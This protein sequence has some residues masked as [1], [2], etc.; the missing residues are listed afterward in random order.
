MKCISLSPPYGSLV[1][2]GLKRIETRGWATS[3]RG[4][5]A[6]HQTAAPGPKGTTEAALWDRCLSEPFR[7]A[8][9][10]QGIGNPAR[11]PRG[12][13]VAVVELL[14]CVATWPSWASV[15]PWFTA[16]H[17]DACWQVPPPEP[18]RSFGDY[19]PGRY[20][21][22]LSDVRALPAPVPARGMPGLW[23]VDTATEAAIAQQIDRTR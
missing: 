15:E 9:A 14:D 19:R 6:I 5:L 21:W 4:P 20:A 17:G 1:A 8:L 16:T 18:E 2:F 12:K 3:Y 7:S 10:A 11:L 22:L 23:R 13:I